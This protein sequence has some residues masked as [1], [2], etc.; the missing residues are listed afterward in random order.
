MPLQHHYRGKLIVLEGLDGCGS[1]TQAKLLVQWLSKQGREA[2]YTKEPTAVPLGSQLQLHIA[3]R[4]QAAPRERPLQALNEDAVALAFAADR[5]DHIQNEIGP[6]LEDGITIVADRYYLSSFAYQSVSSDYNW[7][8]TINS[9]AIRPDITFFLSV[10]PA[11]CKRRMEKQRLHVELYEEVDKLREVEERYL[12]SI[13]D[14]LRDGEVI[15]PVNGDRPINEVQNDIVRA[16]RP[17]YSQMH[18]GQSNGQGSFEEL[19]AESVV[20]GTPEG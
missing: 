13:R 19:L 17:L 12:F 3:R 7:V 2:H 4:L 1:T 9:R 16:V 20:A 15:R 11:I 5:M 14:L 8:K 6:F 10:P 18:A